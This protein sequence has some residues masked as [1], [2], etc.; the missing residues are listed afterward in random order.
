MDLPLIVA[1]LLE[2]FPQEHQFGLQSVFITESSGPV[3]QSK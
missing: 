1:N 3:N 2:D